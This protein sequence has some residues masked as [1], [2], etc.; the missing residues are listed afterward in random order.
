MRLLDSC[1]CIDFLRGRL[2]YAYSLLRESDPRL[3][4]IPAIVEG[5]LRVG[6]EKSSNPE[7]ARWLVDEFMLPFE[8]LPFDSS[9]ARAY[10]RIRAQLERAGKTIGHNDLLIAATALANNAVLVTGNVDEFKR[11]PGLSIESW[12]EM[13]WEELGMGSLAEPERL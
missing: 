2:P 8:V 13:T 11:V 9:C 7:K 10:G 1:I 5:E 3:F 6:A 12:H 4:K